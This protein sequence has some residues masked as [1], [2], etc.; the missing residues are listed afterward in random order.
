MADAMLGRWQL[1]AMPN[2]RRGRPQEDQEGIGGA[3][4]SGV[5]PP[6]PWSQ[7]TGP[8]SEAC[9]PDHRAS[10]ATAMHVQGRTSNRLEPTVG[11]GKIGPALM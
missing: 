1:A 10:K 8:L 11:G 2:S 3:A 7:K 4:S 6:P 5:A 9:F